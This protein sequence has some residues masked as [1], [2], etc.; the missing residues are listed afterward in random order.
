MLVPWTVGKHRQG[1]PNLIWQVRPMAKGT[2]SI[3]GCGRFQV[4]RRGLCYSHYWEERSRERELCSHDDCDDHA[5]RRGLC[6]KHYQQWRKI[7]GPP[8]SVGE[9]PQ[10]AIAHGLCGRHN[11]A[12]G[13]Y[14]DPLGR[15]PRRRCAWAQCES[16]L[17]RSDA[18]DYCNY[19]ASRAW[20]KAHPERVNA[21]NRHY[22]AKNP[23]KKAAWAK[24]W[25]DANPEKR[26]EYTAAR[27]ARI[28]GQFVERVYRTVVLKRDKGLCGL[29]GKKVDPANWHLDHIVP[30]SRGGEHSYANVQV[31]HPFCN[32]S[33]GAK[34]LEY[35]VRLA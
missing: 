25:S 15:K 12:L 24:K 13:K 18:G 21:F 8:C 14:G 9:C 22:N 30:I 6:G 16:E 34:L 29:C 28:L 1:E 11:R 33:K 35:E 32:T 3:P 10:R 23:D 4:L 20:K 17:F 5:S 7:N 31:T 2:C 26:A 27:Q 19:H